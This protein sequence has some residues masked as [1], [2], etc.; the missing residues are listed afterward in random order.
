MLSTDVTQ[1]LLA[2]VARTADVT[3][4]AQR[5]EFYSGILVVVDVTAVAATPSVVPTF[6]YRDS[7]VAKQITLL[8]ATALTGTGTAIYLI[9][10]NAA[11]DGGITAAVA[12]TMPRDWDLFMNHADADSIT[13]QVSLTYL[14]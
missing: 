11:A 1:E 9:A 12:M 14:R 8:A 2:S 10:P 5:N 7:V 4:V 6:R 3:T 13:Y